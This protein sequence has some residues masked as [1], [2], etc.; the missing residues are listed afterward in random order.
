M[1]NGPRRDFEFAGGVA[2]TVAAT[3]VIAAIGFA[4]ARGLQSHRT[5]FDASPP[6][7]SPATGPSP[8]P[9]PSSIPAAQRLVYLDVA[10]IDASNG[11]ALVSDCI[12]PKT[13]DCHV[14]VVA[15]SDGGQ[16]WSK[17]IQVGPR[18]PVANGDGP[19]I[20][21]FLNAYDGFVYGYDGG[22]VTHDGGKTWA[23]LGLPARFVYQ[24]VMAGGV[25]WAVTQPCPK[26]A[27]CQFEVRSSLDAGRTWS[28][29]QPLPAGFDP[30]DA[31]AFPN[32]LFLAN[33]APGDMLI[34]SDLGT[35]WTAMAAQCPANPFN[36]RIATADGIE[37]WEL[38]TTTPGATGDTAAKSLAVSEDGGK[39]WKQRRADGLPSSGVTP[40][41]V[42]SRPHT[43]FMPAAEATLVTHDAG[44]TWT[45]LAA[46]PA[47]FDA[48]RFAGPLEGWATDGDRN[49]WITLDGGE[50]WSVSGSLATIAS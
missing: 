50:S 15:T 37:L 9:R 31:V 35:T 5:A 48:I 41:I 13:S 38:C 2:I 8:Q 36:D 27:Y 3:L 49:I 29:A 39:S 30:M 47:R 45:P 33:Q 46:P 12:V 17:A 28:K 16:T 4:G 1:R 19:K 10:A 44:F 7:Q 32:G 24:V 34:T 14:Y 43:A 20:V 42:S 26:G 11:R 25:V 22:Y 40:W 18:M 21:R 23:G 6:S